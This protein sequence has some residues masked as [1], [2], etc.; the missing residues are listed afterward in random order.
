MGLPKEVKKVMV[1]GYPYDLTENLSFGPPDLIYLDMEYETVKALRDAGFEVIYKPHPEGCASIPAE[2]FGDGVE[3]SLESFDQVS[4]KIDAFVFNYSFTSPFPWT[5]STN[6][7]VVLIDSLF[8]RYHTPEVMDLLKK[9]C[10]VIKPHYDDR[11][12]IRY[13][14]DEMVEYLKQK[15]EEPDTSLLKKYFFPKE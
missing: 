12:R 14:T 3:V 4:E 10:K 7:P 11:S 13:N 15:P 9:R 6:K 1:S 2:I 8:F 5:L